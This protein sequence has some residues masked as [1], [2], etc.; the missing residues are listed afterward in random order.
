VERYIFLLSNGTSFVN[1]DAILR[2]LQ[3]F[4]DGK[5][6]GKNL[7]IV[8]RAIVLVRSSIILLLPLFASIFKYDDWNSTTIHKYGCLPWNIK[9]FLKNSRL[10][11]LLTQ[12][13]SLFLTKN[14]NNLLKVFTLISLLIQMTK[15][16][17]IKNEF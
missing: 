7:C 15:T 5:L 14:I 12:S 1:C 13:N 2:K 6:E 10:H 8:F 9:T 11:F 4:S 16:N 3:L 17:I